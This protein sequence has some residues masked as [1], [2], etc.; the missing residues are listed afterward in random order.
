MENFQEHLRTYDKLLE[1]N[2]FVMAL[3]YL[4]ALNW[5]DQEEYDERIESARRLESYYRGGL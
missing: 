3:D 1:N 5:I 4:Q 2:R